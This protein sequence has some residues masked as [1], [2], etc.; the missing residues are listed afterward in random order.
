MAVLARN[1]VSRGDAWH[2][3]RLAATALPAV[4][5]PAPLVAKLCLVGSAAPVVHIFELRNR[6]ELV[7]SRAAHPLGEH[8]CGHPKVPALVA[9]RLRRGLPRKGTQLCHLVPQDHAHGV[10]QA[11]RMDRR[12]TT[13]AAVIDSLPVLQAHRHDRKVRHVHDRP[14]AVG[15]HEAGGPGRSHLRIVLP[16]LGL[17]Q[18]FLVTQRVDRLAVVEDEAGLVTRQ[19]HRVPP[20]S[21]PRT[22]IPPG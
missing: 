7:A 18:T 11:R 5:T 19:R 6:G 1:E 20:R 17:L 2:V 9:A 10:E 3:A 13:G 22:R 8:P 16:R 15:V 14:G 4:A 12:D 21:L